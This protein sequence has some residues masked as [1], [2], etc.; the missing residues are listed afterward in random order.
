VD[1]ATTEPA[2]GTEAPELGPILHEEI[3]RLPE[4]YRLP[5]ILCYLDGKTN[6][7]AA[8]Q[9]NCPAGTVFSR[10]ARARQR[11][12]A[13]LA[14]RGLVLSAGLLGTALATLPHDVL[15]AVPPGLVDT[16]V[17]RAL[18]FAGGKPG[19]ISDLPAEVTEPATWGLRSRSE[20]RPR[21]VVAAI[22]LLLGVS[23]GLVGLFLW[24]SRPAP[25]VT[26]RL[27][28]TWRI[29]SMNVNGQPVQAA[30]RITF[31]GD[32]I[33]MTADGFSMSGTYRINTR[34]TPLQINWTLPAAGQR[35]ILEFQGEDLAISLST[36][37]GALP[38]DFQPGPGRSVMI[39][40]REQP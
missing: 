27:Q 16:T 12:R 7:E 22:I 21:L 40:R 23:G 3:G 2:A 39:F 38:E 35:G 4:K 28:G 34:V 9:L 5:F 8:Q 19:N 30:M 24:L 15:A 29:R 20:P 10:L 36:A 14:R 13:R 17:H 26:E 18:Q 32:Q 1:V 31:A 33:T 25:T 11:L 6:E 37:G